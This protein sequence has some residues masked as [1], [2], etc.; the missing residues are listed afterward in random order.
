[1]KQPQK[2]LQRNV[3]PTKTSKWQQMPITSNTSALASA[4]ARSK[5]S[6]TPS[7]AKETKKK[8]IQKTKKLLALRYFRFASSIR[9][10]RKYRDVSNF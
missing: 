8:E 2:S 3:T 7:Y 4:G 9:R 1:M 5:R 6:S 10:N